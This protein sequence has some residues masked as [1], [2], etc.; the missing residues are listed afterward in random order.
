MRI[1][2]TRHEF[3]Y[4]FPS[5]PSLR[6]EVCPNENDQ[7]KDSHSQPSINNKEVF[8]MKTTTTNAKRRSLLTVMAITAILIIALAVTACPNPAGGS[9]GGSSGGTTGG[10]GGSTA[11]VQADTPKNLSFGTPA[12]TVTIKST[13]TFTTSEWNTLCNKA[14]AAIGRGYDAAP[15]DAAKTN[16]G[17]YFTN[18]TVSVVLSKSATL[19]CEV[20]ASVPNTIY[21]KANGSTIEGISNSDLYAAIN[22]LRGSW[23]YPTP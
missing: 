2:S 21:F 14:V 12:C 16:I 19:D 13:D 8:K 11:K 15:G 1:F 18:N 22:A 23:S 5:T 6:G 20:K 10:S 9:K 3:S 4:Y 7:D 17:T